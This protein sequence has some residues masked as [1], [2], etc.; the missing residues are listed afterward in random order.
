MTEKLP[1]KLISLLLCASLVFSLCSCAGD[2]DTPTDFDPSA[3]S[4]TENP[5]GSTSVSVPAVQHVGD[6]Y[7]TLNFDP[8]YSFNP[9][10]GTSSLNMLIAGLIYEPLIAVTDNFEAKCVLC[11]SYSTEDGVTYDF[12]LKTGVTFH[13]GTPMTSDDVTYTYAFARKLNKYSERLKNIASISAPDEYTVRI[14]QKD[15]NYG[16]P[17][18]LDIPII[19]A[20]SIDETL[21]DGTGAYVYSYVSDTS[22]M[23]TAYSGYRDFPDLPISTIR[24]EKT[25]LKNANK[26]FSVSALDMLDYD[27][28]GSGAFSIQSDH[29]LYYYDTTVFD[30][31]GFN[32]N[33]IVNAD[34][35][36]AF[37]YAVDRD[38]IVRDIYGNH[39]LAS[40]SIFSPACPYYNPRLEK[41]SE[42]SLQSLSLILRSVGLDDA[43]GDGFLEYP[44]ESGMSDL[45]I[46]FIVNEENQARVKA[47]QLITRTLGSIGIDIKLDV[48]PWEQFTAA[49]QEG[50]F[51]MYYAEVKLGADFDF[52]DILSPGG[53]LNYGGISD[54]EYSTLISNFLVAPDDLRKSAARD[55]A[56]KT[57]QSS[58]I[59][60]VLYK[61][62]VVALHRNVVSGIDANQSDMFYNIADWKI[63]I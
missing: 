36:R 59:I 49:L 10:T 55:L 5:D 50:S 52:S 18:L 3:A 26:A 47:A 62:H 30:Y 34:I 54:D 9:I 13:D 39:A 53:S 45:S 14:T 31:I 17:M 56:F 6:Q 60:P 42:Y 35:R 20:G 32:T 51:D 15:P 7:F 8:A 37:S 22:A 25:D 41:N 44:T 21:P 61:K 12:T 57:A 33:R 1:K 4:D 58:H 2:A 28:N 29:E 38:T 24:L 11:E 40:G 23:L 27:P 16:L 43:D 48:L 46:R 19:K 63:D